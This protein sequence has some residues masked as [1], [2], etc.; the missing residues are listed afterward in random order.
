MGLSA[1]KR[2]CRDLTVGIDGPDRRR[3]VRPRTRGDKEFLALASLPA[4]KRRHYV[5]AR[6][7]IKLDADLGVQGVGADPLALVEHLARDGPTDVVEPA[8]PGQRLWGCVS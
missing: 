6:A 2:F 4:A 5:P 1:G 7:A 3:Y 8:V